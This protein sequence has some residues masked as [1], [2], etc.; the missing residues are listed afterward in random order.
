M[1]GELDMF[2]LYKLVENYLVVLVLIFI[3]L[4]QI[5]NLRFHFDETA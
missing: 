5:N 4:F 2:L 3:F 1:L